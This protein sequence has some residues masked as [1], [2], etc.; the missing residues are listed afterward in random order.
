MAKT[1]THSLVDRLIDDEPELSVELPEGAEES[2]E[3][4]KLG[5]RRDL[6]NLLN[7]KRPLLAAFD[8]DEALTRTVIAFGLKDISTEDLS[9]IGA[10]ERIRRMVAQCI[11]DHEPRL[12]N[13]Q[14][15]MD[16]SP[17]SRG[18]RFRIIA[19][20]SLMRDQEA[21]IYDANINPSDRVIAV[22]LTGLKR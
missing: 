8:D 13:V 19:L 11:R 5:L 20:L 18:V 21:V 9:S 3:H 15:E 1:I 12:S 22:E 6:E 17:N 16:G 14:V 4:Y 2:I 7:S 10:R